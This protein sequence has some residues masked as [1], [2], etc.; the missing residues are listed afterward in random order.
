M[1]TIVKPFDLRDRLPLRLCLDGW[2]LGFI[3]LAA[4]CTVSSYAWQSFSLD[5]PPP[6]FQPGP[7]ICFFVKYFPLVLIGSAV[8]S[9]WFL[10]PSPWCGPMLPP[11]L[12]SL[13]LILRGTLAWPN[14]TG[15]GRRLVAP[16]GARQTAGKPPGHTRH[17]GKP[18]L[19]FQPT[20]LYNKVVGFALY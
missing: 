14:R 15:R 3:V 5:G 7:I 11:T 20:T 8:H 6:G 4:I 12:I 9:W 10:P 18:A 13:L 17:A 16:A 19:D 2:W 1:H